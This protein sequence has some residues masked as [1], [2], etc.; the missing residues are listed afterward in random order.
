MDDGYGNPWILACVGLAVLL[1]LMV[2]AA[3]LWHLWK[4]KK[5]SV[6]EEDIKTM[7]NEGHEQGV[8]ETSE[9][10][11]ISNIFEFGDKEAQDIMTHRK[12]IVAIN[13][14]TLLQD[15][16]TFMMEGKNSRYPVYEETIDH[17]IGILH[18]KDAMRFH[19]GEGNLE[20]PL[21]ELENLLREPVFVHRTKNIEIGRAHV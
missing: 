14:D 20:R 12:N 4:L 15:A 21:K 5:E 9:A 2:L 13:A 1:V 18:L 11:M 17:I 19:A 3:V 16:I 8:L 10:E 6:T 7:V